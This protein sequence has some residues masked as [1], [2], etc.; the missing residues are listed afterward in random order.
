MKLYQDNHAYI[1]GANLHRGTRSYGW[2]LDYGRLRIWLKEKHSV[3]CA[4]IFIGYAPKYNHI[5]EQLKDAGFIL[6]F[7]ETV[8]GAT[9]QIKGNCDADLVLRVVRDTYEEKYD[10]AVIVSSDGDFAGLIKF[11]SNRKRFK[12]VISPHDTCSVLIR[13]MHLP[14]VYLNDIRS[15]VEM[16]LK[17]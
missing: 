15:L 7:K 16:R 10:E 3:T 14:L 5:Y 13:Q 6:L 4:Y 17:I 1:D 9:G 8:I 12:I 11:L 2:I